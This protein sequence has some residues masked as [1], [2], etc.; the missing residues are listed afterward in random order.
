MILAD[1]L[2]KAVEQQ[3]AEVARLTQ[4]VKVDLPAA[5]ARLTQLQSIASKVTP[6]MEA[7]FSALKTSQIKLDD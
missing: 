6:T 2:A 3:K 5:Q 7:A 4:V 1:K